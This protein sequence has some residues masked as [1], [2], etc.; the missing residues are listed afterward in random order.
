MRQ[1]QYLSPTITAFADDLTLD[2]NANE[3]I[4]ERLI[5]GGIDGLIVLGS[6][7]EFYA[8]SRR[9]KEEL[10]RLAVGCAG[11]RVR[12][13]IG[14]GCM[15]VAETAELGNFALDCGATGVILIH[16]YYFKLDEETVFAYYSRVASELEGSIL[17]YNYPNCTGFSL[18]PDM[19]MRLA[20]KHPNIIGVKDTVDDFSHTRKII[21]ALQPEFPDFLIYS[22]MDENLAHIALSGGDGVIGALTNLYPSLCAS[23]R[24]AVNRR[25]ALLIAEHQKI[26]DLMMGLYSIR[27]P[28]MPVMKQA[29]RRR[30]LTLGNACLTPYPPLTRA[31]QD[32]LYAL[33]DRI[34]AMI[35]K[36]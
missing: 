31:E 6:T 14:A 35:G 16:P 24:D 32:R 19:I 13:Y 22:G 29:M 10:I 18:T 5:S 1:I 15:T 21:G 23:F 28:F 2:R 25:D 36:L 33:M 11:G 30:G 3:E 9:Q 8:M 12:T 20:R 7:G 17:L 26:F 34:E 4:I 27:S